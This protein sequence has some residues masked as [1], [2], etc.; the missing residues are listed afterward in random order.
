MRGPL[1]FKLRDVTR[2]TKAVLAASVDVACVEVEPDTGK[3]TIKTSGGSD[4][5][6]ITD[7]DGWM[8]KHARTT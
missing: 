8:A 7:L 4:A 3:I 1:K 5:E 6:K 2:A